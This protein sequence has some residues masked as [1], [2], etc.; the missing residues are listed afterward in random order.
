MKSP[1]HYHFDDL[2]RHLRQIGQ[3]NE[4]D[5]LSAM[6]KAVEA[7]LELRNAEANKTL[8]DNICQIVPLLRPC[9]KRQVDRG[10]LKVY[11]WKFC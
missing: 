11:G 7:A 8:Q 1:D 4:A 5:R 10:I 2:I 3:D 6:D 9:H